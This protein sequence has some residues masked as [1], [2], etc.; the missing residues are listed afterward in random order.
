[1]KN[2]YSLSSNLILIT[3]LIGIVNL[4]F[5]DYKSTQELVIFISILI[6]RYLLFIL[7]KRRFKWSKYLLVLIIIRSVYRLYLVM[8]EAD[9]HPVTKINL[10]LQA[11]ISI[12]AF[13]ILYIVPKLKEWTNERRKYLSAARISNAQP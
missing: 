10:S 7:I 4:F 3:F 6:T 13:A 5:Y 8:G 9:I 11:V 2:R 12:L 1:M